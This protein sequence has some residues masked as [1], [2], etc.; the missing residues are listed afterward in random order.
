MAKST[1]DKLPTDA[2]I[3]LELALVISEPIEEFY[4]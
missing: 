2:T 3:Q 1:N 4:L